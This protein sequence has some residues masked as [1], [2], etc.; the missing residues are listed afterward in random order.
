M[1]HVSWLFQRLL[2][3][4]CITM[5]S[6]WHHSDITVTSQWHHSDITVT[7]QWHHSDTGTWTRWTSLR[8]R[9]IDFCFV[10]CDPRFA[11]RRPFSVLLHDG[12]LRSGGNR[13]APSQAIRYYQGGPPVDSSLCLGQCISWILLPTHQNNCRS[14]SHPHVSELDWYVC[15]ALLITAR[16]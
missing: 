14:S 13:V 10:S 8:S 2:K 5:T 15:I 4:K 11:L 16:P 3:A 12:R 1:L 7:S 9:R 6:Q